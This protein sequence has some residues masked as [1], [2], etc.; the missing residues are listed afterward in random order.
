M[1]R[2]YAI[3][4]SDGKASGLTRPKTVAARDRPVPSAPRTSGIGPIGDV[5]WGT[6]ICAFYAT[7]DDL[8]DATVAY[9]KAGLQRNEAALWAISDPITE[10]EAKDAL[11]LAIPNFDRHLSTGRFELLTSREWYLDGDRFDLKRLIAAWDEKL[12]GALAKGYDGIRVSG[13]AFWV[14]TEDWMAFCE[15]EQE[16]N[17]WVTGRRIIVLCTYP[18]LPSRAAD[19]FDVARTHQCAAV[20]RNGH[21]EFLAT[22]ELRQARRE[23]KKLKGALDLLVGPSPRYKSLTSHERTAL[24]QIVKGATNKEAAR[25]LGISPRT[26]EFHRANVMRKLAAKNTAELVRKVLGE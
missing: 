6:H 16:L 20:R 2:S 26:F 10:S 3:T 24:A 23:I 21:W 19:I 18:L 25:K 14:G 8:L 5:T 17:R 9:F 1:G 22:P 13:N 11:R 4:N 15:Y 7:K 12:R